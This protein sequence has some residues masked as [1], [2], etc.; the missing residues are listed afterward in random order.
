MQDKPQ[1]LF[2]VGQTAVGKSALALEA[3]IQYGG[4]VISAD[5]RQI[6][7]HMDIGT[8]KPTTAEQ[9]LVQHHLID[10]ALPDAWYSLAMFRTDA[11]RAIASCVERGVLPIVAGGTGQ[12]LAALLEGWTVPELPPSEELRAQLEADAVR[13]GH[14][15]LHA[16]LARLDPDAAANI[17]TTNVRRIVRALEVCIGTGKPF[18]SLTT[19]AELTFEPT[20]VWLQMPSEELY[21]RIDARVDAMVAHGLVGEVQSLVTAGYGWELPAMSGIGYRELQ[22]YLAGECSLAEAVQRIKFDTHAFARRQSTWFRRFTT[23]KHTT[24]CTIEQLSSV[25]HRSTVRG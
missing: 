18:S 20:V 16:R 4:E 6:Y 13:D 9:S 19:K 5:S 1:V 17:H 12:Y 15:A 21:Q 2:I 25:F 11:L 10:V 23:I 14:E 3:A 22:P 7:R 24:P 8:A